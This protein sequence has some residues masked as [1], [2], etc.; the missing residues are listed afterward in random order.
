MFDHA[1]YPANFKFA[2][3]E[4]ISTQSFLCTNVATGRQYNQYNLLETYVPTSMNNVSVLKHEKEREKSFV[5]INHGDLNNLYMKTS[6]A[7]AKIEAQA[8]QSAKTSGVS[9]CRLFC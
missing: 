2:Q 4:Q 7:N 8:P 1:N 6:R 9:K 3:L 5:I